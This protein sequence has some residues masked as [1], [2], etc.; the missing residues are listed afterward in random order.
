M[1]PD[2]SCDTFNPPFV[3]PN[4]NWLQE[5]VRFVLLVSLLNSGNR[6]L[7]CFTLAL[8]QTLDGD[9]DPFPPLIAVHSIVSTDNGDELSDLLLLDEVEEFLCI[10]GRGTGSGVTAI[11]EKV[12]IDVWNF[13]F[14]CGLKERVE[15]RNVGMNTTVRNL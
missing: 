9:L 13:E 14:L 6:I 15:V 10:F 11:A 12:D 4:D 7:R 5:L 1:T 2:L 8:D 3:A